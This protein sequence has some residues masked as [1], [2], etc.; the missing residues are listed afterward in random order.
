ME[1]EYSV[2]VIRR[3]YSDG[4]YIEIGP[5]SDGLG[6]IEIRTVGEKNIEYFGNIRLAV[7]PK[8]AVKLGK[9][10][11]DACGDT[12]GEHNTPAK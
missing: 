6:C 10:I 4:R 9:A 7:D 2:D 3:V 8:F 5:D 12:S 1:D 11:M